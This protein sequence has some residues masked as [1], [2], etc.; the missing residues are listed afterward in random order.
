MLNFNR[1]LFLPII[2]LAAC[3]PGEVEDVAVL[4][5]PPNILWIVP[6]DTSPWMAAYGDNTVATPALD[7]MAAEGV[8]FLN[9]FAAN[10]I[11]SPIRSALITGRYPTS[12][13]VH[14]HRRSR[15][16]KGRD[17]IRLPDG[18]LTLPELF[19]AN[20]YETFNIGKD[21]YNFVYDRSVL[22]SAGEGEPGHIGEWKGK[23]FDW[24]ELA[25]GGPFF[26]QIQLRGGKVRGLDEIPVDSESIEL[27]PYYPDVPSFRKRWEDHYRTIVNTDKEVAEILARLEATGE[28][29]NTAVFFISD[30]GMLM[31]RHKQFI[32]D[33]G[34]HVPIIVSYP[35]GKDSIRRHGARRDQ[36]ITTIDLSAASL[37]L[38]GIPIPEYFEGRALFSESMQPRDFVPLSRDRA[39]YT[40]DQIR[41][42]RTSQYKYIRNKYP[43]VPYM[44]PS[45]RDGWD[46][47]KDWFALKESGELTDAQSLFVAD[48][49]PAEELYDLHEDPHEVNNLADDPEY[50]GILSDLSSTLDAWIVENGDK[51]QVEENETEIAAV[52]ARWGEMCVDPRCVEYREKY[53]EEEASGAEGVIKDGV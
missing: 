29:D 21:D 38:A 36:L 42:V 27:P 23:E 24:T 35:N 12:T 6:E 4:Q 20:G 19:R 51:G 15:D 44:Q 43:D 48:T 2:L 22:Y 18:H 45:Y 53:G 13:G 17:A 41:G 34:I 31:L 28:A 26:G 7:A 46:E 52:V 32:Y 49:R 39:D 3:S 25:K 9:A 14:N 11:C 50:A 16:G 47:T 10:P 40:F 5:D 33:G 8:T 30:H 37:E 1:I